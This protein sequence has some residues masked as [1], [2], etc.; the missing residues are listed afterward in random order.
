MFLEYT[1]SYFFFF[2]LIDKFATTKTFRKKK[3]FA[4]EG[5]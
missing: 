2:T 4:I 1:D 5:D 3:A